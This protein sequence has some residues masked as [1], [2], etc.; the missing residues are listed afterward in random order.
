MPIKHLFD[1]DISFCCLIS[2]IK[3]TYQCMRE[4]MEQS[5]DKVLENALANGGESVTHSHTHIHVEGVNYI[6]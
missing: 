2:V 1:N 5:S 3:K 4:V 6:I